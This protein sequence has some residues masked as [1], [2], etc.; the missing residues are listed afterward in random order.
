MNR[1]LRYLFYKKNIYLDKENENIN[2]KFVYTH[3]IG[4]CL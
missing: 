2:L 3:P 1:F 4:S